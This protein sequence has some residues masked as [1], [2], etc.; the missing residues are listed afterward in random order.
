MFITALALLIDWATLT[1]QF[2]ALEKAAPDDARRKA[3]KLVARN[4]AHVAALAALPR[5]EALARTE[6]DNLLRCDVILAVG[7]VAKRH[8]KPAPDVLFEVLTATD[9]DCVPTAAAMALDSLKPLP[10]GSTAKLLKVATTGNADQRDL[11][12]FLL[13]THAPKDPAALKVLRDA[14]SVPDVL[15]RHNAR[16]ALFT[17]TNK[18]ADLYPHIMDVYVLR[19]ETPYPGD[20]APENVKRDNMTLNLIVL[21]GATKLAQWTQDRPAELQDEMLARLQLS[22]PKVRLEVLKRLEAYADALAGPEP[23]AE[24]GFD[25]DPKRQR[26]GMKAI[27][28]DPT[29]RLALKTAA[30]KDTSPAVRELAKDVIRKSP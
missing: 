14:A 13:A 11:G 22:S 26:A 18:I 6:P 9:C 15:K 5:L 19:G 30:E 25:Y 1:S 4:T 10:P 3:I 20:D 2:A 8:Q 21:G 27:L 12:Y 29:M 28:T 23:K 17:A 24:P 7:Q 16:C